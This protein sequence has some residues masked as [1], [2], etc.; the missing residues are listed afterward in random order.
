MDTH[1]FDGLLDKS[2][3]FSSTNQFQKVIDHIR[4]QLNPIAGTFFNLL[5]ND[6]NTPLNYSVADNM[7]VEDILSNFIHCLEHKDFIPILEEQLC[8]M[9]TGFCP[10]GRVNRLFQVLMAFTVYPVY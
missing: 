1:S 5:L 2:V 8:D 9:A 7:K 6:I 3:I 10:E 4:P